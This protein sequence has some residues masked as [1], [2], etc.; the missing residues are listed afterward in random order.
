MIEKDTG[1]DLPG[2]VEQRDAFLVITDLPVPL[3]LVEIDE[4][5]VFEI[6]RNLSLVSHLL[7]EC[8]E[9]CHQPG[10]TVLVDFC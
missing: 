9:F 4:G 5:R 8:C 1:E 2:N 10:P 7:E 3:P 6:R